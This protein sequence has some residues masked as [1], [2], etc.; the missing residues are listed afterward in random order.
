MRNLAALIVMLLLSGFI[1]SCTTVPFTDRQQLS[2][3]PSQ[4]MQQLGEDQYQE[5]LR[6]H[7]LGGSEEQQARVKRVGRR[8]ADAVETYFRQR[9]MTARV[10]EY[11]WEFNLIQDDAVN[12]WCMPGGKVAVYTGLLPVA[13]DET[14]LA[15]V[16]AHEIAHAVADHGN[17]RM[18]QGL[19]VQ[20]GGLALS[21]YLQNR[22]EATRDLWANVY[23]YGAQYGALYPYSRIQEK[24]A[25]RM[26]LTFM[27]MAGY[28]PKA[29]VDFW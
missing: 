8:V 4:T 6:N 27:A 13:E 10:D 15:V 24:E 23:G 21:Q 26:G 22:P 14:G 29:A 28:D 19:L 17:E 1:L 25:D 3:I 12:A 7:E 11:D 5:F 2:F 20:F 9:G 18:S 16:V